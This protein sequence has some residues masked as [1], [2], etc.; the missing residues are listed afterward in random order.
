MCSMLKNVR[1]PGAWA[2]A[3]V[4][5]VQ[6]LGFSAMLKA[7]ARAPGALGHMP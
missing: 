6:A 5:D 4:A 7:W 3:P 2:R 1:V